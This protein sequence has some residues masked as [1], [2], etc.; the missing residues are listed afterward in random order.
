M[1]D[2]F[3]I[4]VNTTNEKLENDGKDGGCLRNAS[5]SADLLCI[6]IKRTSRGE[7]IRTSGLL[8]PRQAL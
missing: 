5:T 2:N 6:K 3:Q 1:V 4:I 8:R 7:R